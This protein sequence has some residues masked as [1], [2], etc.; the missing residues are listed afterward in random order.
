MLHKSFSALA[1]ILA[2]VL[3]PLPAFG[4]PS[5]QLYTDP[6]VYDTTTQTWVASDEDFTL[7]AF[8]TDPTNDAILSVALSDDL[9][10]LD[11]SN[12]VVLEPGTTITIDG[13]TLTSA[14]FVYGLPP[15]SAIN[16]DG[17]GGDLGPHDI[18]PTAFAEITVDIVT[19]GTIFDVQPL[20]GG[21][22]G[23]YQDGYIYDFEVTDAVE[24]IHFD[25]YTLNGND[26]IKD[27]APF[28]HDAETGP[29]P[30]VPEPT[31]LLLFGSGLAS[32]AFLKR[33]K[34]C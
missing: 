22:F 13:V 25:L 26:R 28:S 17:G 12:N 11:A 32:L 2:M 24:G 27:F 31:T 20:S 4:I 10:Y 16:P 1:F 23:S 30:P 29:P 7:S 9:F 34:S 5:L 6:G 18:Y 14:D 33:R 15:I 3:A 19:P 21:G 8:A